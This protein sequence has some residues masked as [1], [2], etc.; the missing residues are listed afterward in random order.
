MALTEEQRNPW[1]A[2]VAGGDYNLSS[3][4]WEDLLTELDSLYAEAPIAQPASE[5][6]PDDDGWIGWN[7]GECPIQP[8]EEFSVKLANGEE[9]IGGVD[10]AWNWSHDDPFCEPIIAYCITSKQATKPDYKAQRDAL[11]EV[12]ESAIEFGYIPKLPE[13]CLLTKTLKAIASVKGDK[14]KTCNGEGGWEAAASSTSYF[15][16]D[17]PDCAPPA[18]EQKPVAYSEE[19]AKESFERYASI[20]G[21][22]LVRTAGSYK[23]QATKSAWRAW[24]YLHKT[25][26]QPDYKAQRDELLSEVVQI[27]SNLMHHRRFGTDTFQAWKN[28]AVRAEGD[29]E[30]TIASVKGGA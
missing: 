18:S 13:P 16:K 7:G 20:R 27:K 29:L 17:C 6:K 3:Q 2:I 14:C 21:M 22:S 26:P 10:P 15:W 4:D 24:N 28:S 8:G 1:R 11:L 12:L 23:S 5:Q 30:A 9:Y 19:S 25:A